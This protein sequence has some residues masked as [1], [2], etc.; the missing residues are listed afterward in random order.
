MDFQ[1]NNIVFALNVIKLDIPGVGGRVTVPTSMISSSTYSPSLLNCEPDLLTVN[2]Y[3]L[4]FNSIA[5]AEVEFFAGPECVLVIA[6]K[7]E[8]GELVSFVRFDWDVLFCKETDNRVL[9]PSLRLALSYSYE[10]FLIGGI[11]SETAIWNHVSVK[12]RNTKGFCGDV[13]F[14]VVEEAC[15]VSCIPDEVTGCNLSSDLIGSRIC[16][17]LHWVEPERIGAG[18][19]DLESTCPE[20]FPRWSPWSE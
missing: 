12:A 19:S 15:K 10:T 2:I 5:L 1:D 9:C 20:R 18:V 4:G 8:L 7:N 16:D 13:V 3:L 11:V 14:K 6:V 17:F